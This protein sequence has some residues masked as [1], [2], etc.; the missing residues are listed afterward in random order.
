M[1]RTNKDIEKLPDVSKVSEEVEIPSNKLIVD[2]A[3]QV[4]LIII[5]SLSMLGTI[6]MWIQLKVPKYEEGNNYFVGVQEECIEECNRSE[7]M[8]FSILETIQ[9]K[10]YPERSDLITKILKYDECDDYI[11]S[12]KEYDFLCYGT[13]KLSL[14]DLRNQYAALFEIIHKN[15]EK[16]EQPRS[17]ESYNTMY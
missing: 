1:E 10:V 7:E 11:I 4:E 17:N 16:I 2:L 12:F 6:K 9:S 14:L 15:L 13:I 8:S 5:E 3:T